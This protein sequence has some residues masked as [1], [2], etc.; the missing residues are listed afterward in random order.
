MTQITKL[1]LHE[2]EN[3]LSSLSP[4]NRNKRGLFD[5]LGTA[6]K[7][8]TGNMDAN[9]AHNLNIAIEKLKSESVSIKGSMIGQMKLNSEMIERFDNFTTHI[10]KEQDNIE[11]FLTHYQ[12]SMRNRIKFNEDTVSYTQQLNQINYNID[13]LTNHISNIAEAI[14]LAR[15]NIISKLIL[16]PNE[17]EEIYDTFRKQSIDIKSD[18]HIYELLD[19]QAYYN[20]SKI[21][22]NIQ[23]PNLSHENFSLYHVIPLPINQTKEIETKPYL[24]HNSESVQYFDKVC[25][26]IEG[27]Y[28][29]KTPA[30]EEKTK[31]SACIRHLMNN[32]P[33][34]C[35]IYDVGKIQTIVQP[36]PNYILLVNVP[37]TLINSTCSKNPQTVQGTILIQYKH[38][39][40]EINGITYR[41]T[42]NTFWDE[43]HI[44]PTSYTKS[45]IITEVTVE[46][47]N[48]E[49]MKEYHFKN[50][51]EIENLRSESFTRDSYAFISLLIFGV[52]IISIAAYVFIF[53]IRYIVN[54]SNPTAPA[55]S[56]SLWPSLYSK[57]GGVTATAA[58]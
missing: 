28:Y 12:E 52:F 3:K 21:I 41:D 50:K 48:M 22:F 53:K 36:E 29:C 47:L 37:V 17:L 30:Y 35:T 43:I 44:L 40:I 39:E 34:N 20:G 14:L 57:G 19:Q 58:V 10:N 31:D 26:K 45:N 49:K 11:K 24:I 8:I 51:Q 7:C 32:E 27:V 33:A 5:G 9:D 23:I 46:K 18:E 25:P 16:N 13:L 1:K 56:N 42:T 55:P 15:L 38:C 6:I 2:L 4:R 54:D